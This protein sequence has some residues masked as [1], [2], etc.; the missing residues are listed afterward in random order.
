MFRHSIPLLVG[1]RANSN[2]RTFTGT[3]RRTDRHTPGSF[4][5]LGYTTVPRDLVRDRLFNCHNNDFANTHGRNVHNGLRRTSNNALFLS[6]VNSVPL[7]L[8]AHLLHILRSQRIIP[9]NNRPRSIGIEVVDT[10]R[11]GL[12]SQIGSNDFHRSL[13]CHLGNLRITLPTLHRHDSGSRLLS[14]L[15]TRRTNNRAIL[16]SRPTHRTLL[17]F[18]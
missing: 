17:T 11:H 7:T 13:C 5:T 10:A 1:N 15:L 2:G 14:F 6:R 8:R 16:V 9:V 3:I 18:T 4:I 12:L